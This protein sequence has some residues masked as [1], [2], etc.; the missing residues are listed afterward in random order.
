MDEPNE[1]RAWTWEVRVPYRL[2]P[3]RLELQA[4]CLSEENRNRYL[5]WLWDRSTL[6][7][8]ER[9]EIDRW[10]QDRAIVPSSGLSEADRAAEWLVQEVA[11]DG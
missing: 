6:A 9:R 5:D 4:V 2:A 3:Y 8:S 11:N 10:I 7:S 1:P